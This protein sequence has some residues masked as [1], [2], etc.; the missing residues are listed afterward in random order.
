MG[1]SHTK[2]SHHHV[3]GMSEIC[4]L[5]GDWLR[6][7]ISWRISWRI[8]LIEWICR[9]P[10]FP[11]KEQMHSKK[12]TQI[13]R[14]ATVLIFHPSIYS[15]MLPSVYNSSTLTHHRAW[16]CV[17]GRMTGAVRHSPSFTAYGG[18]QNKCSV[19]NVPRVALA[20]R[21]RWFDNGLFKKLTLNIF[22]DLQC[23]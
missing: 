23:M 17:V 5:N 19:I 2:S 9:E 18:E 4:I 10:S 15:S 22:K 21:S 12:A 14:N 16:R 11:M 6:L 8:G 7:S 1:A 3:I 13:K 20:D